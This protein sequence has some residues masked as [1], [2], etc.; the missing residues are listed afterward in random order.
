MIAM[1][2]YNNA[3][4]M[5]RII[6]QMLSLLARLTHGTAFLSI[7]ESNSGVQQHAGLLMACVG[8]GEWLRHLKLLLEALD[9][10]H[11]ILHGRHAAPL[12]FNGG[13][14]TYTAEYCMH[15]VSVV[16]GRLRNCCNLPA[17]SGR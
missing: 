11:R 1:N 7:Y 6:H 16:S 14:I 5:P 13:Q 10:P 2:L 3:Y 4:L 12:H 8:A 15:V 9:Y 17:A